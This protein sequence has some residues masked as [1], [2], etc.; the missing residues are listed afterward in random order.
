MKESLYRHIVRTE[1]NLHFH[2]PLKDT[3]QKCDRFDTLLKVNP[4][5][6]E[7]AVDKELHLRK[8]DMARNKHVTESVC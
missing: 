5:D 3:C 4:D 8:A 2:A 7:T 6:L 1:F